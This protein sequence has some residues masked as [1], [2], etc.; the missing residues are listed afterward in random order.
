MDDTTPPDEKVCPYCAETIEAAAIRCRHCRSDLSETIGAASRAPSANAPV[1]PPAPRQ[2]PDDGPDELLEVP[3][4]ERPVKDTVKDTAKDTATDTPKH[5]ADKPAGAPAPPPFLASQRLLR[6]LVALCVVLAATAGYAWW[7]SEHRADEALATAQV[8]DAGLQAATELTQRVLTYDWKTL[9]QDVE[10]AKAVLTPSF[11][12]EY[13]ETMAKVKGQTVENQVELVA[14]VVASSVVTATEK[15]VVALVFV[16]QVSTAK[17]ST[18]PRLDQNRVLV[19][20]ARDGGEWR[21][22]KMDAF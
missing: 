15:K 5:P 9:E 18:N 20:L 1:V 8:R 4:A 10:D 2:P 16:N 6:G 13:D 14:S 12:D 22:S 11:R 19:T 3:E 7:R 17:G 21:V